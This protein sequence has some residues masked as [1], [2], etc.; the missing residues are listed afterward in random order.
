MNYSMLGSAK[1][2]QS[3]ARVGSTRVRVRLEILTSQ[4]RAIHGS[5]RKLVNKLDFVY[6]VKIFCDLESHIGGYTYV[7]KFCGIYK[8]PLS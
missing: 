1:L 2:G 4:A 3:S 7:E 5:A 6:S 8:A